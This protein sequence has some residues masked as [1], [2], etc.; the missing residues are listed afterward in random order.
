M[1]LSLTTLRVM[2]AG[3]IACALSVG[4]QH[5]ATAG[6]A[7]AA[8]SG[9]AV[10]GLRRDVP[11]NRCYAVFGT[12]LA[13]IFIP[14]VY[15]AIQ[16]NN[17]P[18]K[19]AL[20][21]SGVIVKNDL[22]DQMANTGS[23]IID[24]PFWNDI[25]QSSA[26]NL[27]DDTDTLATVGKVTANEWRAR[28]AFLNK[29]YGA[30]DLTV[31][32]SKT[33]KGE[34]SPMTRIR[35]RF[36]TYWARQFQY[37]V[38][39][40][41]V[42]MYNNNITGTDG[43]HTQNDMVYAIHTETGLSAVAANK[44]SADAVISAAMTMGDNFDVIKA[45]AMHSGVYQV[46]A[47]LDQITFIK[48]SDNSMMLPFYLGKRVIIDDGLTVRAGT[49]NGLVYTTLLLGAGAFGYGEGQPTTPHEVERQALQGSGGG[50]ECIVERRTW[51]IHPSGWDFLS[52]SVAGQSPT[53]AELRLAANWRRPAGI[54]RKSV[55]MAFL[56]SN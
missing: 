56:T 10:T 1:K 19:T 36:G 15:G 35:N 2:S 13:D 53:L 29:V 22:L 37:R 27:S 54:V 7:F 9:A 18:E 14:S 17:S 51:L 46:L 3:L 25:D 26:P 30:S 24:I 55:P 47:K 50:T 12:G 44:I 34:G 16:P 45:I 41:S 31:E 5:G 20:V 43:F 42:G 11:R 39:A 28:N 40:Q 8:I 21:E 6:F 38:I 4:I 23:K 32:L 48:P 33:Q 49:T 52:G